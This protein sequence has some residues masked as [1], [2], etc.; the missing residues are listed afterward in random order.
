[1]TKSEWFMW[2]LLVG[3][4]SGVIGLLISRCEH[5]VERYLEAIE[6]QESALDRPPQGSE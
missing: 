2:L 1:M 4:F 3:V 6:S 5:Y